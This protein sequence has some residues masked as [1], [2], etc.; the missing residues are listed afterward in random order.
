MKP[1]GILLFLAAYFLASNA[2]GGEP[3]SVKLPLL[4]GDEKKQA[5]LVNGAP[6]YDADGKPLLYD[7]APIS[8]DPLFQQVSNETQFACPENDGGVLR[9]KCVENGPVGIWEISKECENLALP[10]Q[11][12]GLFSQTCVPNLYKDLCFPCVPDT[13]LEDRLDQPVLLVP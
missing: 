6:V 10:P 13:D 7:P 5:L 4:P 1:L 11:A 8:P 3:E 12:A 2:Y 9:I